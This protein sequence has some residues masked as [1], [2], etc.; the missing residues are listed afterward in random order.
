MPLVAVR[1]YREPTRIDR[2]VHGAL[3]TAVI[4]VFGFVVF[5]VTHLDDFVVPAP[6]QP[7]SQPPGVP[8]EGVWHGPQGYKE[9]IWV[10]CKIEGE[11]DLY[12]CRS[13]TRSGG[14]YDSSVF[15]YVGAG[16]PPRQ[17]VV[18]EW[19]RRSVLLRGGWRLDYVSPDSTGS[20][21]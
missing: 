15:R 21:F 6:T 19:G 20:L 10:A 4:G 11:T 12:V 8:T 18:D 9:G 1:R 13:W 16:S 7:T 2:A 5:F 3:V 14:A 17:P